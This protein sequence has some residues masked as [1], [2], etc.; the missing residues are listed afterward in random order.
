MTNDF[1]AGA[2]YTDKALGQIKTCD[3]HGFPESV[4][5][6]Q[7]AGQVTKIT[8]GMVLRGRLAG[9]SF[10]LYLNVFYLF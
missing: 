7:G 5:T 1:F 4:T 6:F 3:L 8:G 9:F 10:F 2:K